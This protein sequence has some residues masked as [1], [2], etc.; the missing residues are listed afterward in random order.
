MH[1]IVRGNV[2]AFVEAGELAEITEEEYISRIEAIPENL[3]DISEHIKED[4]EK[5]TENSLDN[6][7]TVI[8]VDEKE[9]DAMADNQKS[10]ATLA[11]DKLTNEKSTDAKL[12]EDKLTNEKSTDAKL[13]DEKIEIDKN[14]DTKEQA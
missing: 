7:F 3:K 14:T 13:T 9:A 11:E 4:E 2:S 10:D 5:A 8:S 1:A 6:D 12:A